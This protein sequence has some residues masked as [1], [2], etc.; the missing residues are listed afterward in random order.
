M[1]R[2]KMIKFSALAE[3]QQKL[4]ED[5]ESLRSGKALDDVLNKKAFRQQPYRGAGAETVV[6][7]LL[8]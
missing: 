7:S 4:A 1:V 3:W 2:Y 6:Y 5:F 8:S